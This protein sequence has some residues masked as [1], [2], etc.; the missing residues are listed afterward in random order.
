MMTKGELRAQLFIAAVGGL[1]AAITEYG[2]GRLVHETELADD[3]LAIAD[4]A[5]K[6]LLDESNYYESVES[7]I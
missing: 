3:A 7:G 4:A 5:M 2:P 6:R 1:S